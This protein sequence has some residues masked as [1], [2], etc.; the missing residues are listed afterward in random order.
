LLPS[1][2]RALQGE[3]ANP[4]RKT[5]GEQPFVPPRFNRDAADAAVVGALA[6]LSR[7]T[8]TAC[9]AAAGDNSWGDVAAGWRAS[10]VVEGRV[11]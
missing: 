6:D 11:Q 1:P 7:D 4:L 8:D 10:G 3:E 9:V 2:E 5:S